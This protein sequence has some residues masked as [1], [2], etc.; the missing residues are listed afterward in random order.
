[1]TR[2]TRYVT[3]HAPIAVCYRLWRQFDTFPNLMKDVK[4]VQKLSGETEKWRWIVEGPFGKSFQWDAWV[5]LDIPNQIIIWHT[6]SHA[7]V[8][9]SGKVFFHAIDEEHTRIEVDMAYEP[10]T[11]KMGELIAAMVRNP[12]RMVAQELFR[13]KHHVE[14][15][16]PRVTLPLAS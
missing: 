2:I 3:I 5:D 7:D 15:G 8:A 11:S 9:S 14:H 10:Q 6:P 13:F 12:S 1:M 4:S 16:Q